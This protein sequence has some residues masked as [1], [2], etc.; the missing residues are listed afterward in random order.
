MVGTMNRSEHE[1]F[2]NV[3]SSEHQDAELYPNRG[4][5]VYT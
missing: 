2:K 1:C 4:T 5:V 3:N